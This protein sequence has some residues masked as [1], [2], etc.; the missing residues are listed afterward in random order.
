M[1]SGKLAKKQVPA[2][3]EHCEI[4]CPA[5]RA[6]QQRAVATEDGHPSAGGH[7]QPP[8][9]GTEREE[10][11][12]I[13][14]EADSTSAPLRD[15]TNV[16]MIGTEARAAPVAA[17]TSLSAKKK[18]KKK[19]A[20]AA[21]V[22]VPA[23]SEAAAAGEAELEALAAQAA[24]AGPPTPLKQRFGPLSRIPPPKLC[25]PH[26]CTGIAPRYDQWEELDTLL[27]ETLLAGFKCTCPTCYAG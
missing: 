14:P 1:R 9:S 16:A 6:A 12:A 8:P 2:A 27:Y 26:I 23:V 7:Q 4:C 24:T 10:S 13:A 15:K 20:A 17:T 25:P 5:C 3:D 22:G 21:P 11:V 19:R 18:R